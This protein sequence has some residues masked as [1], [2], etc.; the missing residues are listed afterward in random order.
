MIIG[1]YSEPSNIL[2][3]SDFLAEYVDFDSQ[4]LHVASCIRIELC[5]IVSPKFYETFAE[6]TVGWT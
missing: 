3:V 5:S 4:S 1:I 6:D 2:A